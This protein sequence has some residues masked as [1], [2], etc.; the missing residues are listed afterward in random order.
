MLDASHPK[1]LKHF[2]G[3]DSEETDKLGGHLSQATRPARATP[4]PSPALASF[5]GTEHSSHEAWP[6]AGLSG[7]SQDL[8]LQEQ[9]TGVTPNEPLLR[10]SPPLLP[11][12]LSSPPHTADTCSL[13][14]PWPQ[15]TAKPCRD[16]RGP[17]HS[18][19]LKG[20]QCSTRRDSKCC[21]TSPNTKR[22]DRW[23][24]IWR[25]TGTAAE[26]RAVLAHPDPG[27]QRSSCFLGAGLL[28]TAEA[29][30]KRLGLPLLHP[31]A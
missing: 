21:A 24:G 8:F 17:G 5:S 3:L 12:R 11:H 19:E 26:G 28:L 18:P 22:R 31:D 10:A 20:L 30:R 6:L 1:P 25:G 27:E 7:S 4:G 2:G 23:L 13:P 14:L 29:W 9:G 15:P 16:S